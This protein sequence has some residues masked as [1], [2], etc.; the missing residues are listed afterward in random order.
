MIPP[1]DLFPSGIFGVEGGEWLEQVPENEEFYIRISVIQTS[2]VQGDILQIAV[3]AVPRPAGEDIF[4]MATTTNFSVC[5]EAGLGGSDFADL[6]LID[7]WA[8]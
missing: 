5:D 7:G 6:E 1:A 8:W 2:G 3:P 4:W